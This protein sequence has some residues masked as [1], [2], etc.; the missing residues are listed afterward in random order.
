M[1]FLDWMNMSMA[2][3]IA[4]LVYM[5][6]A[7]W[8]VRQLQKQIHNNQDNIAL[9]AKNPQAARRKLNHSK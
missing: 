7:T 3:D 4:C 8:K 9:V 2:V 5:C 6:A 1:N